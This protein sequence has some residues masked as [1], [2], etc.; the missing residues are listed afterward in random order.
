MIEE[1]EGIIIAVDKIRK[2]MRWLHTLIYKSGGGVSALPR[3]H[4]HHV[5]V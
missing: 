4:V 1:G 5:T 3:D 2:K